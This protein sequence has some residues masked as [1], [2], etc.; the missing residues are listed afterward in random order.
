MHRLCVRAG[1]TPVSP[2]GLRRTNTDLRALVGDPTLR[3]LV[4]ETDRQ[5][6]GH[7]AGSDT[8][9]QV[10]MAPELRM[11]R[12]SLDGESVLR[13]LESQTAESAPARA[14]SAE[15]ATAEP[16]ATEP[17]RLESPRADLTD[18]VKRLGGKDALRRLLEDLPE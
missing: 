16:A 17:T 13:F 9:E 14:T 11:M 8:M 3:A 7:R 1:V 18:L 4:A 5:A 15:P 2:H 6:L 12:A 10:Y